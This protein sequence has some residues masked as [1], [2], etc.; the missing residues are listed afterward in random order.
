MSS[1]NQHINNAINSLIQKLIQHIPG[2]DAESTEE[3]EANA[4]EFATEILL[5]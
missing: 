1:T 3:R 5:K 2:E 4:I